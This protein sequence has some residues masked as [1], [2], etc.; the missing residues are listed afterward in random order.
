LSSVIAQVTLE[1]VGAAAVR[2]GRRLLLDE[3]CRQAAVAGSAPLS[4][5][6]PIGVVVFWRP[7]TLRPP[8]ATALPQR[9]AERLRVILVSPGVAHAGRAILHSL[10]RPE[11]TTWAAVQAVAR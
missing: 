3:P 8:R 5:Q 9:R 10:G 1:S 2:R 4:S 6:A 7:A 11:Q